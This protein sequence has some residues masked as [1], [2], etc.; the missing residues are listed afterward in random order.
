[1]YKER[2]SYIK[3]EDLPFFIS[4][5]DT[6]AWVNVNIMAYHSG[7]NKFYTDKTVAKKFKECLADV[8]CKSAYQR[9]HGLTQKQAVLSKYVELPRNYIVV[10]YTLPESEIPKNMHG[11][12]E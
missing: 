1:M 6:S 12:L 4:N 10:Q 7:Q 5:Q 11:I 3:P 2:Y 9:A 8:E